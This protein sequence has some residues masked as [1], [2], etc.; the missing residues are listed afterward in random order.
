MNS[1]IKLPFIILITL[2]TFSFGY[3]QTPSTI[4]EGKDCSFIYDYIENGVQ[5]VNVNGVIYNNAYYSNMARNGVFSFIFWKDEKAFVSINGNI[6]GPYDYVNKS[7][8]TF[9]PI[10]ITDS[11][12]YAFLYSLKGRRYV[13]VN[14]VI[15]GPY[16]SVDPKSIY[17]SDSGN[18]TFSYLASQTERFVVMNG[19]KFGPFR[20]EADMIAR[21]NDDS[22]YYYEF[23]NI[24]TDDNNYYVCVNGKVMKMEDV[25]LFQRLE[26]SYYTYK[27]NNKWY[28][29]NDGVSAGP[30]DEI[31][32]LYTYKA[33]KR[34]VYRYRVKDEWFLYLNGNI[35]GP[36]INVDKVNPMRPFYYYDHYAYVYETKKGQY[37]NINGD[38]QGPYTYIKRFSI[39]PN[40]SYCYAYESGGKY[41]IN[42]NGKTVGGSHGMID[43]LVML[44]DSTYSYAYREYRQS[45]DCYLVING[46]E[47][48]P[49][50]G[51]ADNLQVLKDGKF[52]VKLYNGRTTTLLISG[53]QFGPYPSIDSYSINDSGDFFFTASD[54]TQKSLW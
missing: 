2:I 25:D 15:L 18:Y 21:I 7:F 9:I 22:L 8:D 39:L 51:F 32:L 20:N 23:S 45:K 35:S 54:Q 27:E 24:N 43:D 14:G 29:Y 3:S 41:Y 38:I 28:I 19:K 42:I 30:Y 26:L 11:G 17:I 44:E 1:K 49:Y 33:A 50:A 46:K 5:K 10:T 48:G 40:H 53:K 12:K 4:S 13:N 31:Q 47:S 37:I 6:L 16:P 34:V 52:A 36:F